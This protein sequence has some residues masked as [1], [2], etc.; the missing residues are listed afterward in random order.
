MDNSGAAAFMSI[1]A[2]GFSMISHPA[3]ILADFPRQK[4]GSHG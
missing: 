1:G 4:I 2:A 3:N